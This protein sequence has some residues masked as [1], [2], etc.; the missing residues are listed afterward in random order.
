MEISLLLLCLLVA[1]LWLRKVLEAAYSRS[2][3]LPPQAIDLENGLVDFGDPSQIP[4]WGDPDD[5]GFTA[6]SLV[7]QAANKMSSCKPTDLIWLIFKSA[8]TRLFICSL[9]SNF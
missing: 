2:Y 6:S 1:F 9:S 4:F 8:R 3:K 7:F 5:W